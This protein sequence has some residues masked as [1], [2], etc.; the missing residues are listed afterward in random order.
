MRGNEPFK[1][2]RDDIA[3]GAFRIPMR[4]NETTT[5]RASRTS[6]RFRIPMRGNELRD[7]EHPHTHERRFESP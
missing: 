5:P 4:G 7:Q 1:T 2:A 3:A 6:G